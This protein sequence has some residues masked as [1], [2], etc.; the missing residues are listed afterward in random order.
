MTTIVA[1]TLLRCAVLSNV[2]HFPRYFSSIIGREIMHTVATLETALPGKL[3]CHADL[4]NYDDPE[5]AGE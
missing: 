4:T 2:P 3:I 5:V 1:K